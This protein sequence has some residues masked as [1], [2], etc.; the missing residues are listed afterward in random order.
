[1]GECGDRLCAVQF[2]EGRTDAEQPRHHAQTQAG[3]A[4]G[5]A[6]AGER[7]HVPAELPARELARFSLLGRRAG[8][9]PEPRRKPDGSTR[10]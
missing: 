6:N 5:L 8:S 7:P 2:E 9:E 4:D 3:S 10:P 1:M